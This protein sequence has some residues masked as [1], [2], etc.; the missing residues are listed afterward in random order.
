MEIT[1][2][3]VNYKTN[4]D[5]ITGFL[6]MPSD[7]KKYPGII[8]VHEIFGLDE[9]TRDVAQRIAKEGYVVLAPHLFSSNEFSSTLTAEN[10]MSAMKFMMSIPPE[11]QRDEKYRQEQLAKLGDKEKEGILTVFRILFE[12]RP[13]DTFTEYLFAGVDYLNS[14]DNVNGKIGS[15]GFCF[16]GGMSINLA[17]TKKTDASI[18]FYGENP[19]PVDKVKN[20]KGPVMGL[21]GGE[22]ARINA[23][24]HELVQSMVEYKKPFTMRVFPNAH[25]AFFNDSRPQTYNEKAARE[26]WQMLLKFFND[27]LK[28]SS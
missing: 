19:A 5:S 21:Y 24:I 18:I 11:K 16:G 3:D 23:H 20:V 28:E 2:K 26:S 15:A 22:D 27:N 8:L 25:H 10:I 13:V 1:G 17:C 7:D 4:D 14:L 6:A 9:H 12:N